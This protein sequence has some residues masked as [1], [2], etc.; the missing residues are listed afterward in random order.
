MGHLVDRSWARGVGAEK[1]TERSVVRDG[2]AGGQEL[3]KRWT[4]AKKETGT[5]WVKGGQVLERRRTGVR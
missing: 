5:H 1:E 2:A 3:G 4:R